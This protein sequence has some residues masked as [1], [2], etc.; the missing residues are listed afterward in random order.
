MTCFVFHLSSIDNY[1]YLV[2]LS[3]MSFLF[4]KVKL[5]V[6]LQYVGGNKVTDL[7]ELQT[8]LGQER[9]NYSGLVS[10]QKTRVTCPV[11]SGHNGPQMM[12]SAC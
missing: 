3:L 7:S 9:K 1:A 10:D 4:I 12:S 11:G 6:N 8:R 2:N 5:Q